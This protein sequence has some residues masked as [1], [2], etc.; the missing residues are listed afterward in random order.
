MGNN[1]SAVPILAMTS[2]TSKNARKA[3]RV[4][5]SAPDDVVGGSFSTG[6]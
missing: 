3:I 2:V 1:A 4:S 6:P 5:A